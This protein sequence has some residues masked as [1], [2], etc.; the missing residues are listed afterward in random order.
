MPLITALEPESW[1]QLEDLVAAMDCC[2]D[3]I[4][5]LIR[6]PDGALTSTDASSEHEVAARCAVEVNG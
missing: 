6:L 5:D 3:A 2:Q 4:A 1:E